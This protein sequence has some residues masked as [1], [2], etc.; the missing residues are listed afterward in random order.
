VGHTLAAEERREV[1]TTRERQE[2]LFREHFG[3]QTDGGLN[4][5]LDDHLK[6][7]GIAER[8]GIDLRQQAEALGVP[9]DYLRALQAALI[10]G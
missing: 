5:T 8:L 3:L 6:Q 2:A 9:V 1:V 7:I 10:K 4:F